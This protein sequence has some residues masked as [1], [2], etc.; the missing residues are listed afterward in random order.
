[1]LAPMASPPCPSLLL[2]LL[3]P[4]LALSAGAGCGEAPPPPPSAVITVA[5]GEILAGAR[6]RLMFDASKSTPR[7]TLVPTAPDPDDGELEYSWRF[8]GGVTEVRGDLEA[9]AVSVTA[10]GDSPVHATLTV[11]NRWGGQVSALHTVPLVPS[12]DP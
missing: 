3:L 12:D 6:T 8:A 5:P 1:M 4:L 9:V 7:L 11:R 2:P 10:G